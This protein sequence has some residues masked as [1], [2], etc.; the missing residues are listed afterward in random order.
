MQKQNRKEREYI[1]QDIKVCRCYSLQSWKCAWQMG[2]ESQEK[3][4]CIPCR[5]RTN[6][7]RTEATATCHT[8]TAGTN[9]NEPK[10]VH[11]TF[12]INKHVSYITRFTA[13]FCTYTYVYKEL[14][15]VQFPSFSFPAYGC[16]LGKGAWCTKFPDAVTLHH[17]L[18]NFINLWYHNCYRTVGVLGILFAAVCV[19]QQA[20]WLE[21]PDW[22][23]RQWQKEKTKMQPKQ[24]CF[25]SPKTTSPRSYPCVLSH[26]FQ[27]SKLTARGPSMCVACVFVI[28]I[29]MR[30]TAS[31]YSSG[32]FAHETHTTPYTYIP[33]FSNKKDSALHG[34]QKLFKIL[35]H[36]RVI[37]VP[38][39]QYT[40]ILVAHGIILGHVCDTLL[41]VCCNDKTYIYLDTYSIF[42]KIY[43][44]SLFYTKHTNIAPLFA[45]QLM[46]AVRDATV[47][48]KWSLLTY[49][50]KHTHLLHLKLY[51]HN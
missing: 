35:F 48:K 21:S 27:S 19:Q 6:A 42:Y 45:S 41:Y 13:C 18:G 38:C 51:S 50:H 12:I 1:I 29:R 17:T 37:T 30:I 16:D 24:N 32:G 10:M 31:P 22:K 40:H 7:C 33:T 20:P 46:P 9:M 23:V 44:Y 11:V 5:T 14:F 36:L 15:R 4:R 8:L 28:R 49:T 47:T 39:L 26:L 25:T 34:P 3:K 2:G 43:N